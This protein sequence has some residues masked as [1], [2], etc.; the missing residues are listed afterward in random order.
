MMST[1]SVW[2]VEALTL[3]GEEPREEDFRECL[4][5]GVELA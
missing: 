1:S 5:G 4:L 2:D 3:S